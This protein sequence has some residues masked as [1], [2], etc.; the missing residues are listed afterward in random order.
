MFG[1]SSLFG[2]VMTGVGAKGTEKEVFERDA[3]AVEVSRESQAHGAGWGSLHGGYFSS[4]EVAAPLVAK[5]VDAARAS[6]PGVVV[7]LGGGTGFVLSRFAEALGDVGGI[8]LVDL[9]MAEEQL[10]AVAD[11]RIRGA[12][13]SLAGFSRSDIADAEKRFMFI[14][15]STLHYQG[16][17]GAREAIAHVASQMRDGEFFI[18]Q[19]AC[20]D[21]PEDALAMN[22]VYQ[23]MGTGKWYPTTRALV[24]ML[25]ESGFSLESVDDAPVLELTSASLGKRYGFSVE[26]TKAIVESMREFDVGV[27]GIFEG[28]EEGFVARLFY[29]IFVCRK[30]A[31]S[32][33]SAAR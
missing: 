9:D 15:R 16:M 24:E 3:S 23:M 21:E 14:S 32:G 10:E 33:V 12:R 25:L 26:H 4:A 13:G 7:D 17:G 20:F 11:P 19:T 27:N 28:T 18:H 30:I 5:I 2:K 29:K 6:T 31:M 1:K 22:M 8:E